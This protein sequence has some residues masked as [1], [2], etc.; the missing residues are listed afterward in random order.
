MNVAIASTFTF[1]VALVLFLAGQRQLFE[2]D[3]LAMVVLGLLGV[4]KAVT[5]RDSRGLTLL[6]A[7]PA[8]LI[9]GLGT[10]LVVAVLLFLHLPR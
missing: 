5:S 3:L 7:L 1:P 9:G 10:L 6:I 8:A 2:L 4:Q